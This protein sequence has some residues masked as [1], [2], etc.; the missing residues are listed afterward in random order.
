MTTAMSHNVKTDLQKEMAD[1]YPVKEGFKVRLR[2]TKDEKNTL[3]SSQKWKVSLISGI[4][5]LIISAP[6]LYKTVDGLI[7]K[8]NPNL[9]VCN[10]QGCPTP[11]GLA[12]HSV[13]FILVIRLL[14]K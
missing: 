3:S 1:K 13:V 10:E 5:F 4:L 14:M 6:L 11:L 8:I 9:S 2:D 12:I 7:R